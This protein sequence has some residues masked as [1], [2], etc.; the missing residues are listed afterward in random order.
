MSSKAT[1][2]FAM[3]AAADV[4]DNKSPLPSTASFLGV[5]YKVNTLS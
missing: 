5:V 1:E 2:P 3:A 4:L